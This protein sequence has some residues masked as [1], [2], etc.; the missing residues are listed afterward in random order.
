MTCF[1]QIHNAVSSL[2]QSLSR[3]CIKNL[4][5]SDRQLTKFNAHFV[6]ER[7]EVSSSCKRAQRNMLW[8]FYNLLIYSFLLQFINGFCHC[9]ASALKWIFFLTNL[10]LS[11]IQSAVFVELILFTALHGCTIVQCRN[12][13]AMVVSYKLCAYA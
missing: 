10:T 13:I 12:E 5:Y 3:L 11:F 2:I 6:D 8:L 7:L 1:H 4:I 9:T